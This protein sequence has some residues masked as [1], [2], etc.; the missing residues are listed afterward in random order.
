MW[1][2]SSCAVQGKGHIRSQTPCQDKTLTVFRNGVYVI[3]LSDGAGSAKLSHF[4]AE[5]VV[6][7]I[8][9]LLTSRFDELFE[10]P[11]GRVV[12]VTIM[13]WL[14]NSIQG[15]A[16]SRA[17]NKKDLASTL[18]AVA[19]KEERFIVAHIGD[20]VVGY[21]DGPQLKVASAPSNGE[22]ANETYFVTSAD[23]ISKMKLFKGSIRDK[24][25]FVVMSDGTEQSMYNK[26][27][28]TL[29]SAIIKLMQR[30]VLLDE[31]SMNSQL[32]Q[33]FRDI[34]ST[35]THDDCSIAILARESPVLRPLKLLSETEKA[36]LYKISPKEKNRTKRI[37]RYDS[38]VK[39]LKTPQSCAAVSKKIH[40][41]YQYTKRHL[42][43]LCLIGLAVSENG[44]Y[45]VVC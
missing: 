9:D 19:V 39:I 20:G 33:T 6:N 8:A 26:R 43:H 29:S 7:S 37:K 11:D 40:L 25:G 5:C 10:E 18:L 23:A 15:E 27:T 14:L 4:G 36:E 16:E 32:E 41:K 45:H 42:Q 34:I 24:A 12:K 31:K 30:N 3:S 38:L 28:S 13:T 21:L 1:K 22:H 44:I 2:Y 17:C 35:K